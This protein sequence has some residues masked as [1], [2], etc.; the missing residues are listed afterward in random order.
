MARLFF[1]LGIIAVLVIT[2]SVYGIYKAKNFL[3]GPRINIDS[4]KD[5]EI[6]S[7]EFIEIR[8]TAKNISG[9]Y[10]NG[11]RVFTDENGFFKEGLLIAQGYNI[12]EINAVDKFNHTKDI[13]REII[14]K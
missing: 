12:I 6:V 2:F 8:G 9:L 1:N 4:P 5:G 14:L 10:L 7:S 13:K 3:I 11:R